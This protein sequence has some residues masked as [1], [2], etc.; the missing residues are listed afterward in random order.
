MKLIDSISKLRDLCYRFSQNITIR[1]TVNALPDWVLHNGML[2]NIRANYFSISSFR[3]EQGTKL[4]L[5]EQPA[6]ALVVL[7]LA[8]VNGVPSM[9]LSIR[10]EPGLVGLTNLSST[11]QST[12]SNY[13]RHHGG[14]A[15][16]FIQIANSPSMYGDVLYDGTDFDWGEHYVQKTKRFLI[17][18]L[19][20]AVDPE[21][22]LLWVPQILLNQLLLSD[23]LITNDL[24]VCLSLLKV[25]PRLTLSP[26]QSE[27]FSK[28]TMHSEPLSIN[29]VDDLGKSICFVQTET[30]TREV[31]SWVQPLLYQKNPKVIDLFSAR[32]DSR[33]V[34][35]LEFKTQPGL[36]GHNLWFP[37]K[38]SLNTNPISVITSAEGGRFFKHVIHI[39]WYDSDSEPSY[40]KSIPPNV[41]WLGL[42]EVDA[43]IAS[44][45]CTSLEL[46]MVWSLVSKS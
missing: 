16:P 31:S 43:L 36:C 15:T 8:D 41:F 44:P 27:K 12:P 22:G 46:R 25:T 2:C 39:N 19:Y 14:K 21:E 24:R 29:L 32:Q 17:I 3:N 34:F 7:L 6:G 42:D 28:T 26:S 1:Q 40:I 9:L 20:E 38:I 35:A 45:L 4:I 30:S 18:K 5:M 10:S 23:H 11:I 33:M 37:A 13:L